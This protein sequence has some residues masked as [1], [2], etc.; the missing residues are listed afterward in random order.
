MP[1]ELRC[2]PDSHNNMQ[3]WL[4]QSNDYSCAFAVAGMAYYL[5]KGYQTFNP[6][7][8]SYMMGCSTTLQQQWNHPGGGIG[9]DAINDLMCYVGIRTG[10]VRMTTD[11]FSFLRFW[12]WDFTPVIVGLETAL[13]G[14]VV[15]CKKVY[16]DGTCVFLD[17]NPSYGVVSIPG[18][19]LPKYYYR[20]DTNHTNPIG[21]I[22]S[23]LISTQMS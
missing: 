21:R 22:N 23:W 18:D 20:E 14:H 5:C 15:I 3:S 12:A 13:G 4:K 7:I 8:E 6:D 11:V 10:G 16:T 2:L 1:C 9:M 19:K 17:P